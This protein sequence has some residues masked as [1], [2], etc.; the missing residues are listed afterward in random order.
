MDKVTQ[1]RSQLDPMCGDSPC[2]MPE[3]RPCSI[4]WEWFDP[5]GLDEVD[6]VLDTVSATTYQ[7]DLYPF[8]MMK[9]SRMV[10][11][12]WVQAVINISLEEE[13]FLETFKEVLI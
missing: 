3:E 10:I 6:R 5:V 12:M 11:S 4:I 7:L 13:T 8:W 2:K 1:F 9:A